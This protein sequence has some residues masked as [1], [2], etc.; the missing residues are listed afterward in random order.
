MKTYKYDGEQFEISKPKNCV[1]AITAKGLT[2]EIKRHPTNQYWDYFVVEDYGYFHS[3]IKKA[4]DS[5]CKRILAH[6]KKKSDEL[7]KELGEFY[8]K[9]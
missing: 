9:L 6:D 2:V 7:C 8:D 3:A 5:A 1:M 4:V